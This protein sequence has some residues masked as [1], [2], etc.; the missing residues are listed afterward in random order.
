MIRVSMKLLLSRIDADSEIYEAHDFLEAQRICNQHQDLNLILLDWMMPGIDGVT[1]IKNIRKIFPDISV[2]VISA[3]EDPSDVWNAMD[4]GADGFITKTCAEMVLQSAIQLVLSG[5]KYLPP[6][7][8]G[9]NRESFSTYSDKTANEKKGDSPH[10]TEHH[11]ILTQRQ[12]E[13]LNLLVEGKSNKLIARL[14]EI[15]DATVNT[16]VSAIFKALDVNSRTEAAHAASLLG[17]N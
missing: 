13:V 16:H 9:I 7:L 15:S 14:L 5:G 1:G 8:I 11:N 3:S 12:R 17:L 10:R 2:I 6:D 4:N